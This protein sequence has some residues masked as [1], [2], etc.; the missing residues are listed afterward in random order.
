MSVES[1]RLH[2][3]I[4]AL[5]RAQALAVDAQ[6]MVS[7]GSDVAR[8][9]REIVDTCAA[10]LC[11]ATPQRAEAGIFA[12]ATEALR[13]ET[14]DAKRVFA[15]RERFSRDAKP[16]LDWMSAIEARLVRIEQAEQ[17]RQ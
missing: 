16:L 2:A 17:E 7:S 9:L 5:R 13:A 10:V 1:K 14:S 6:C 11:E 4:E 8:E 3:M 12:Q 15:G